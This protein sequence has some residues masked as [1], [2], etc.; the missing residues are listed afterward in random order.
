MSE[1]QQQPKKKPKGPSTQQYVPIESIKEGIV[2]MKDGSMRAVILVSSVN[3]ALKNEDEKNAIIQSYQSFINS[4]DFPIQIMIRSRKLH[5][6]KYL[7]GIAMTAES[8]TNELL[9]LQTIEYLSFIEELLEYANIMEKRFF[10]VIPFYPG[11]LEKISFIKKIFNPTKAPENSDFETSKME[12]NQRVDHVISSLS[13]VGLRCIALETEE[14]IEL[15][16]SVYNP[17]TSGNEKITNAEDLEAPIIQRGAK[18]QEED[19]GVKN[20]VG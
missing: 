15:Y 10:L 13:S 6:D 14:L 11:G 9:K 4:L 18:K 2:M 5:L 19:T 8:Q 17:E 16:Y 3:F 12:L 20:N 7:S 1:T